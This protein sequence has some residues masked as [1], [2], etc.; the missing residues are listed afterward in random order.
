MKSI[1][2][3]Q[4]ANP[5]VYP[6]FCCP[7]EHFT[8]FKVFTILILF[9]FSINLLINAVTLILYPSSIL[10]ATTMLM[11]VIFILYIWIYHRYRTEG[12]YGTLIVHI[13]SI[14]VLAVVVVLLL[15]NVASLIMMPFMESLYPAYYEKFSASK[16]YS[17]LASSLIFFSFGVYLCSVYCYVVKY[18]MDHNVKVITI[19][20]Q[21]E[22]VL[23]K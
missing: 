5:K 14:M 17:S 23:E 6:C 4:L 22:E 2:T 11:M 8:Y 19:K 3:R 13:M 9:V 10:A 20:S 16:I 1:I 21:I 12:I 7:V 15:L 18:A